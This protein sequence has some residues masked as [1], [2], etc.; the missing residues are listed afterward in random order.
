VR[1]KTPRGCHRGVFSVSNLYSPKIGRTPIDEW[2]WW[3][4]SRATKSFFAK[5]AR[6]VHG[7]KTEQQRDTEDKKKEM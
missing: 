1:V 7:S 2:R 4:V 3:N 5:L 6:C